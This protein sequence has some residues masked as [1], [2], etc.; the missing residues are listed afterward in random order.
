LHAVFRNK[1]SHLNEEAFNKAEELVSKVAS[2]AKRP[3]AAAQASPP[4][5]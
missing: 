1:I 5:A 2:M 3:P 4:S